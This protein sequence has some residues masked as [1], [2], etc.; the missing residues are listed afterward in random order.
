MILQEMVY[1]DKEI[2]TVEQ[3]YLRTKQGK[4]TFDDGAF[5]LMLDTIASTLT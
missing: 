3:M 2:C 1:P 5:H 4:V